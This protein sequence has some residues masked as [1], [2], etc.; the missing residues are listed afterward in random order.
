MLR[1][2]YKVS[3]ALPNLFQYT[4]RWMIKRNKIY[5][6]LN[7][8]LAI[9]SAHLFTSLKQCSTL[10]W[11]I[12]LRRILQSSMREDKTL[13]KL[14]SLHNILTIIEASNSTIRHR[15]LM[16]LQIIR[17]SLRAQMNHELKCSID[18][19]LRPSILNQ[20][21]MSTNIYIYIYFKIHVKI[22]TYQICFSSSYV[23]NYPST[24]FINII[25]L[26][27]NFSYHM[28]KKRHS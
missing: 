24:P 2:Q 21:F 4:M 26:K 9:V 27:Y 23:T 18:K 6:L 11:G 8:I 15:I 13:E 7:F 16:W 19:N 28:L 12:L 22:K 14:L 17:P 25:R 10:W 1:L 3:K 20:A 5:R